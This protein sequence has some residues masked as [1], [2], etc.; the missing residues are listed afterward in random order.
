MEGGGVKETNKSQ[1]ELAFIVYLLAKR[2]R[3]NNRL[4]VPA[5]TNKKKQQ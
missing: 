4:Y 2:Q 5:D 3:S 1:L